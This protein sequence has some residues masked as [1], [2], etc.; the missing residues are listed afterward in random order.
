M[1][2][3][4][5]VLLVLL[6]VL[7]AVIS[8]QIVHIDNRKNKET[9]IKRNK[10]SKES[11]QRQLR[12][13]DR[14]VLRINLNKLN[15]KRTQLE[16]IERNLFV[17]NQGKARQNEITALREERDELEEEGPDFE[18]KVASKE[19]TDLGIQYFRNVKYVGLGIIKQ[20]RIAGVIINGYLY[21]GSE[22]DVIANRFTILKITNKFIEIGITKGNISQKIYLGT[23]KK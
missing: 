11:S 21:L 22:G 10:F 8:Y 18:K 3:K 16:D 4:K 1:N 15:Q 14:E 12:L 20:K 13:E 9:S 2:V 5:I 19:R 23:M 6:V 17:I 7:L